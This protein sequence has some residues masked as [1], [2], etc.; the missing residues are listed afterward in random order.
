MRFNVGIM[1]LDKR[2]K[3]GRVYP[4]TMGMM[5]VLESLS[6]ML[7]HGSINNAVNP[8]DPFTDVLGVV[9][10]H[11]VTDRGFVCIEGKNCK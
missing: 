4:S 1:Q 6:G 11:Y 2:N 9:D 10:F 8:S 3:N 7:I 5:L